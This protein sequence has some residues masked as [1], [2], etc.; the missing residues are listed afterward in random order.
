MSKVTSSLL[1]SLPRQR[2]TSSSVFFLPTEAPQLT[3][4]S[5]RSASFSGLGLECCG[6]SGGLPKNN[7]PHKMVCFLCFVPHK[8]VY[9]WCFVA[10]RSAMTLSFCGL[11]HGAKD[12]SQCCRLLLWQVLLQPL[13]GSPEHHTHPMNPSLHN[14][15]P[16]TSLL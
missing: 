10:F 11:H 3:D 1:Q 9:L 8:M 4:C 6:A 2:K 5:L 12:L 13:R 7:K 16:Q 15:T 14:R